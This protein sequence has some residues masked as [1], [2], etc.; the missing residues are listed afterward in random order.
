LLIHTLSGD[1]A[2][3]VRIPVIIML[4]STALG[5]GCAI[6]RAMSD[7]T[8]TL[9]RP[10]VMRPIWSRVLP[11]VSASLVASR[12]QSLVEMMV[13]L[14]IVYITAVGPLLGLSLLKI[15]VSDKAAN[16]AIT[17]GCAISMTC[18]LIR[19]TNIAAL[20]EATTLFFLLPLSLM[21]ALASRHRDNAPSSALN[22]SSAIHQPDPSP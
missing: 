9:G 13:D 1:S 5:S 21:L 16:S 10:S 8:A 19:W 12:G 15:Q 6:L 18:Y 14:N 11:V 17:A 22:Q 7:A 20:P 3:M 2:S 4:V